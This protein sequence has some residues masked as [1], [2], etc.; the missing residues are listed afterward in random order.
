M[1]QEITPG[2][3]NNSIQLEGYFKKNSGFIGIFARQRL[4]I[5]PPNFGNTTLCVS[6]SPSQFNVEVKKITDFLKNIGYNGLASAELKKD[7][8]D[9]KYKLFEIN[10]RPWLHFW[11]SASCGIDIL[12]LSY[13]DAVG[14]K[15]EYKQKYVTGLKSLDFWSDIPASVKMILENDLT[16][17]RW[18]SS[19]VRVKRFLYFDKTDPLPFIYTFYQ[20]LKVASGET[21]PLIRQSLDG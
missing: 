5:W 12:F 11:L 16:F 8:R 4:R 21:L 9:G 10:A 3:P 13:L 17:R 18:L 19:L 1:F 2:P 20:R 6:I 7:A 14:E 15:I